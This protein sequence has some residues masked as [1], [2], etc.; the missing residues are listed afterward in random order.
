MHNTKGIEISIA[1]PTTKDFTLSTKNINTYKRYTQKHK[2]KI[3]N[4]IAATHLLNR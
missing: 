4:S 3:N 1:I 2:F